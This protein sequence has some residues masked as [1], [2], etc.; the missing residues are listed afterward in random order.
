MRSA[1][2]VGDG[3]SGT[4]YV[5][6][7]NSYKHTAVNRRPATFGDP[8][9]SVSGRLVFVVAVGRR[10]LLRITNP[11]VAEEVVLLEPEFA[12]M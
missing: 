12:A 5:S 6:S 1:G 2:G 4:A 10:H 3:E 11:Q 8:A 9:A 7:E